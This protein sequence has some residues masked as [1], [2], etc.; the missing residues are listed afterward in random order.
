M[1]AVEELK[2][3]E[4]LPSPFVC[5]VSGT[6]LHR[7][8]SSA[9]QPLAISVE[10]GHGRRFS[11]THGF[12]NFTREGLEDADLSRWPRGGHESF[13]GNG[14]LDR[15]DR[16]SDKFDRLVLRLAKAGRRSKPKDQEFYNQFFMEKDVLQ[17][18]RD[19][20]NILRRHELLRSLPRLRP[21]R[22]IDLGCGTGHVLETL[23]GRGIELFGMEYAP[24]PLRSCERRVPQATL[25][26]GD[27]TRIPLETDSFDVAVS[28][29]VCEHIQFD[30]TAM[31]EAHR[32]LRPGGRFIMS[33]PGNR[34]D[35]LYMELIG[36]YR[37]Y[38][39]AAL[40]GI[41][42]EVGFSQVLPLRHYPN[43][44]QRYSLLW[45]F[46]SAA[47]RLVGK[48]SSHR[49]SIYTWGGRDG[50][51]YRGLISRFAGIIRAD[52]DPARAKTDESTF[53][54]AIK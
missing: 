37:H 54:V 28:L 2:R 45:P 14:T 40:V 6:R 42:R 29:E 27:M 36:H 13:R 15:P 49:R 44:H 19:Y 1:I 39:Q 47:D 51:F 4:G 24:S 38:T 8:L 20:R 25:F 10:D 7:T 23:A 35:P 50:S 33:V 34:H 48:M 3:L 26:A 32:I 16:L 11:Q 5:P 43:F 9:G 21:L 31:R 41:L 46:L 53:V 30:V 18:T 17:F 12:W 52:R 22:V